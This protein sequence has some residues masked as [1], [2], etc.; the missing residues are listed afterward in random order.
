MWCSNR[1]AR[2]WGVFVI[3]ATHVINEKHRRRFVPVDN[4]ANDGCGG[5]GSGAGESSTPPNAGTYRTG[6][7]GIAID[8]PLPAIGEM[9]A[10]TLNEYLQAK[11]ED[12]FLDGLAIGMQAIDGDT[13]TDTQPNE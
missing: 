12:G 11:Y 3:S 6:A 4:N 8:A 13:T 9:I 5:F 1:P 10:D 7:G 2:G